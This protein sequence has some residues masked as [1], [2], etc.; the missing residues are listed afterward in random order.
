MTAPLMKTMS[1]TSET[2]AEGTAVGAAS[3]PGVDNAGP[4][5][6]RPLQAT[7]E[8]SSEANASGTRVFMIPS[9]G[10]GSVGLIDAFHHGRRRCESRVLRI[11][12]QQK[13]DESGHHSTVF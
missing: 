5:E 6:G 13:P 3:A 10:D 8:M 4:A 9:A 2:L 12:V 11:I 7:M 1:A